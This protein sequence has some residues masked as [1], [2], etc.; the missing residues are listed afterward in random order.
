[1]GHSF[2]LGLDFLKANGGKMNL[3]TDSIKL[4]DEHIQGFTKGNNRKMPFY[5][6]RIV[7]DRK[8]VVPPNTVVRRTIRYQAPPNLTYML[9][10]TAYDHKSVL[11][12]NTLLSTAGDKDVHR[13]VVCFRNESNAFV[14][15][16]KKGFHGNGRRS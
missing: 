14:H 7:F 9:Q 2:I 13:A 10:P 4:G 11:I 5:V 15:L 3:V 12:P 8:V 1:M 16:K 6:A